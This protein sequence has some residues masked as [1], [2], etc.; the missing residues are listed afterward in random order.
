MREVL[1]HK[2]IEKV[3][4]C[5]I[6]KTVMD[7]CKEYLPGLFCDREDKRLVT[8]VGCGME[9]MRSHEVRVVFFLFLERAVIG[10][11]FLFRMHLT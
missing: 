10:T 9:F 7:V 2:G 4:H 8:H 1:K 3:V 11:S 6:D 5:E